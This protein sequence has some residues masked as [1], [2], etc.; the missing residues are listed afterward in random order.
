M[1]SILNEICWYAN[2]KNVRTP[3]LKDAEFGSDGFKGVAC[4]SSSSSVA[5]TFNIQSKTFF[6]NQQV[7]LQTKTQFFDSGPTTIMYN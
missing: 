2:L 7:K 3:A 1:S 4:N 5:T 6:S